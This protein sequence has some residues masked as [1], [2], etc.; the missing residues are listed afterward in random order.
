MQTR[1]ALD[2][3]GFHKNKNCAFPLKVVCKVIFNVEYLKAV[4]LLESVYRKKSNGYI[5]R[6]NLKKKKKISLRS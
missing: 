4:L 1:E 5:K 3:G 6:K 2:F